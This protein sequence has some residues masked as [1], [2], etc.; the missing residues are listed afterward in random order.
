MSKLQTRG[1]LTGWDL[2]AILA[3][4]AAGSALSYD[5]LRQMAVAIHVRPQL[6]YVFPLLLDGFIA[7]GVRAVVL[8]RRAALHARAYAWSLFS[9]A[10]AASVWANALHAVTLN[11]EAAQRPSTG[12]R[13][14]NLTVGILSTLAPLALGGAVHL[15][16]VIARH[17]S[18]QDADTQA[19]DQEHGPGQTTADAESATGLRQSADRT[20]AVR[21]AR[22]RRTR[23]PVRAW[24]AVDRPPVSPAAVKEAAGP[25]PQEAREPQATAP[26]PPAD[27][28]LTGPVD[29]AP[30][31]HAQAGRQVEDT[32]EPQGGTGG[33]AVSPGP[34]RGQAALPGSWGPSTRAEVMR[35]PALT[36]RVDPA[37]DLDALL[38]I[39]RDA[40]AQAG[41]L[42]RA[43]VADG[44][45]ASGHKIS[46][47]RVTAV[48]KAL[49]TSPN[50]PAKPPG[51]HR[52]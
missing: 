15:Y 52:R 49:R 42:N 30:S 27:H 47:E 43:V 37:A 29:P 31:G 14:S 11:N 2:A 3:L 38:P 9:A 21:R 40:A 22:S 50:P 48:M 39:A 26:K 24:T 45:R 23:R 34:D 8:L 33:P 18:A 35:R 13:L 44:I 10:T 46:N 51:R 6:T 20:R 28:Q 17:H 36:A 16:I 5:A 7:Y 41:R 25:P 1:R 12:L 19:G 4:G 32:P